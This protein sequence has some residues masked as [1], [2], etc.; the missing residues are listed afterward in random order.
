[1]IYSVEISQ[2]IFDLVRSVMLAN[3]GHIT[4]YD[5]QDAA[6]M[7]QAGFVVF[8]SRDLHG[9]RAWKIYTKQA[10]EALKGQDYAESTYKP[11][12]T[13][14]DQYHDIE[15]ALLARTERMMMGF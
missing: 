15:G 5:D 1:M 13:S 11:V 4:V 10:Q 9:N 12:T 6:L 7:S 2:R 3:N 14:T 8:R